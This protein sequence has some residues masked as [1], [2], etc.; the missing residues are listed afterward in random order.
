MV[1][2]PRRIDETNVTE[3]LA[4][5]DN[6]LSDCDGVL[7]KTGK[8]IGCANDTINRLQSMGK[9]VLYVTNNS[10]LS[11]EQYVDKCQKLGFQAKKEDIICSSY[12]LAQYLYH[13][14]F[15][16]TVYVIGE[17][18]IGAE[19]DHVG[20]KH[21]GIGADPAPTNEKILTVAETRE[22]DADVGAVAIGLDGQ[23]SFPKM[24][25]ATSYLL[26][27]DI[28]FL[29]TNPDE[30]V[31]VN[32]EDMTCPGAGALV[33]AVETA[34]G[35]KATVVGKPSEILFSVIK[36]NHNLD[37]A[38]TLMIGD[39]CNTDI[40]FGKCCGLQTLQVLSGVTS[41]QNLQQYA[42]GEKI[43]ENNFLADYYLPELGG[44]LDLIDY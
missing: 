27:S 5:F 11:R 39:R 14:Q 42:L 37:P 28:L 17:D 6:V 7:W 32:R 40:L 9:K 20:I 4:S 15:N 30:M 2:L 23:F 35:R 43:E 36:R 18:G 26:N 38:R 44:L 8:V 3:F 1:R 29:A 22:L 31:P 34:S 16:K 33:S 13:Q 10:T 24:I 19:L 12:V 41:Y 21:T 25:M